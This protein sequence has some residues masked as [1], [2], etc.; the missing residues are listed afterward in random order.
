MKINPTDSTRELISYAL[1]MLDAIYKPGYGY[2]K[3]G[4]ILLELKPVTSGTKRL[5]NDDRYLRDKSLMNAVDSLNERYGRQTL[6]FG[7]PAKNQV[8][9]QMARNYLSPSFTTDIKQILKVN[10]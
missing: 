10:I 6:R 3:S 5:F 1:R 9:W 8:S 7:M 4:V 2:R